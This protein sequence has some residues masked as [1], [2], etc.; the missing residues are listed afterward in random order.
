MRKSE[1]KARDTTPGEQ[2]GYLSAVFVETDARGAGRHQGRGLRVKLGCFVEV[3]MGVE[4]AGG[5]EGIELTVEK[6]TVGIEQ[7]PVHGIQGRLTPSKWSNSAR[8]M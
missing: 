7:L 8:E 3:G 6:V 4:N 5:D 2:F 1:E